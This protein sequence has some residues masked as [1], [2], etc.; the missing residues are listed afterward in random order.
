[1]KNKYAI[2]LICGLGLCIFAVFVW[3][4]REYTTEPIQKETGNSLGKI[5]DEYRGFISTVQ[6]KCQHETRCG[7]KSDSGYSV[8]SDMQ[9]EPR[10]P[11]LVYSFGSHFIFGFEIDVIRKFECEIHT[12][13]PSIPIAGH[14]IP[15]GINFHLIGLSDTDSTNELGWKMRQLSTIR[16]SLNHTNTIL[17]ILKLDI[18]GYE[19]KAIP[20]MISSGDFSFVRQL[21]IEVHFG[22]VKT[23]MGKD[24]YMKVKSEYWGNVTPSEQLEVLKQLQYN[25]FRVFSFQRNPR[26][27]I[28]VPESHHQ[29]IF[30]CN[31]IS[32]ININFK[33]S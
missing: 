28:R 32:L 26:T 7:P 8:C 29:S 30:T 20:N 9:Y 17:D 5:Y 11:C 4:Q 27:K 31:I 25:G 33:L 19:W 2:I 21:V 15:E 13:D 16:K 3:E 24:G 1:M 6:V 23:G 12:F 18:E 10:K 14:H 22:N